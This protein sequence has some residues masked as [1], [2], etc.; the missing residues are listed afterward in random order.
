MSAAA[1][2]ARGRQPNEVRISQPG[3]SFQDG[4]G[5]TGGELTHWSVYC[6]GGYGTTQ[7]TDVIECLKS[8]EY[9][10]KKTTP[11]SICCKQGAVYNLYS[12]GGWEM[13][14]THRCGMIG[15]SCALPATE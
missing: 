14:V 3:Q 5:E 15:A 12:I 10:L 9:C 1:N 11:I 6:V 2:S 13:F 8:T 4:I 7:N